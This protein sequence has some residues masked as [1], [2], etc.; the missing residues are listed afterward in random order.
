MQEKENAPCKK[1]ETDKG[2][3]R[4]RAAHR[5]SEKEGYQR[6]FNEELFDLTV[7]EIRI[8]LTHEITFCLHNGLSLT[9]EEGGDADA[10]A[11]TNRV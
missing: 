2:D 6:E 8:S 5:A 11:Y 3:C 4:D 1:A 7:K 10:V 9:E